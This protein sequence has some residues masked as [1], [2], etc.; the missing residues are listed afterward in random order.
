MSQQLPHMN[1]PIGEV[2]KPS[3]M[4]SLADTEARLNF[5]NIDYHQSVAERHPNL[6]LEFL[7]LEDLEDVDSFN[8]SGVG[9]GK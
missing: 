7:H 6:V 4:S 5:G 9:L 3:Y 1:F 8:I 2:P